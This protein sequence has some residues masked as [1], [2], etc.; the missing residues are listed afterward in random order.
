[1]KDSDEDGD[2]NRDEDRAPAWVTLI[3]R[4]Q[5]RRR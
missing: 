1:M 5:K 3:N 4:R 2:G